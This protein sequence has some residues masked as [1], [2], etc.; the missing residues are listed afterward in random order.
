MGT[1]KYCK[2]PAGFLRQKHRECEEKVNG[3][4]AGMLTL[5]SD[6]ING[7]CPLDAVEQ[8]LNDLARSS[9]IQRDQVRG[10]LIEGWENCVDRFLDDGSLDEGE[11]AKLVA[12]RDKFALTQGELD[13]RGAYSKVAKAGVLRDIMNGSLP[14]RVKI[15]GQLPFNFQK[16]ETLV[17]L[18]NGVAYLEDKTRTQYV[19]RSSGVSIRIAKGVYY[20]AGA[21]QGSP[22][23]RTERVQVDTGMLAVTNKH[24]YFGGGKK[25]LRVPYNK[26][27]SFIP[28]SDGVG[29][30]RDA[31]NAKQQVLVTG[32]G[33]FTYNMLVNLSQL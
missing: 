31:V 29:I 11:E 12:L 22:I 24:V 27:V 5:V 15:Q 20:R 9:F 1:C 16:S 17:W 21:F 33:W 8:K 28:Y 4:W 25:S 3:A 18:F 23:S 19:G 32:D 6:A 7:R 30:M 13:R 26:I 2:Q 10:A 14:D